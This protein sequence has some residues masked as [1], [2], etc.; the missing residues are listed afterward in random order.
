MEILIVL[1]LILLN[2]VFSMAEIAIISARRAKLQKKVQEGNKNAQIALDLAKSPNTFLSTVQIGITVIG[3]FAGAF[4]GVTIA[5][6]LAKQ[7][8]HIAFL[9]P[10]SKAIALTI[11]VSLIT[12][13]SLVIGE[14]FPKR[15][16]LNNPEKVATLV[17][18]AMETLSRICY[19]IVSLL[20][21]STDWLF[22]IMRI[23]KS[24]EPTVSDEEIKILLSEG[25][26][27]GVFEM[28]EKD[29]VERT[30]RLSD[31]KVNT[32]MTPRKEIVWL[33]VDS[34]FKI[35]RSKIT[36]HQHAHFPVCRDTIDKVIGVV[37]TESLLTDF[38]AEEKID[39]KKILHKPLFIPESMDGLKVLELFKKSG[40]H[41]ALIV[42]E[43]GNVQGLISLTDILEAIVGDIPTLNE[44]EE[45]E[46]TKRDNGTFLVDGITPIDDF[47]DYFKIRKLPE[48]KTGI[49]H[50]IGGFV[51]NTIG[52]IPLTGDHFE[53]DTLRFE[54]MDMD[55]NRVDKVLISLRN[56]NE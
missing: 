50:T 14:L 38:L 21:L 55:G 2:G 16:A 11:V 32:L 28:A 34:S 22:R 44:L 7:F 30:F 52:R 47:K 17:A 42:D 19:P 23:K 46:I 51:T 39:L 45:K 10:Y 53:L 27:T 9:A 33:D 15:L 48:E 12:Y 41:M 25:T 20:S 56:K 6:S 4:G 26:K 3:I 35:I 31:K 40:I 36:E 29:I 1:L 43:Y 24:T 49:F 8:A 54:I 18:P 5:E 13:L 37:R